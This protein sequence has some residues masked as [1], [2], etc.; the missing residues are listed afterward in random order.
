MNMS[1]KCNNTLQ[2]ENWIVDH[3]ITILDI[4]R[5]HAILDHPLQL[6]LPAV[7]FECLG[8][9]N[10]KEEKYLV[11]CF[12]AE[13]CEISTVSFPQVCISDFLVYL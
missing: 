6:L 12:K 5:S 9:V 2:Q 13:C 3:G 4:L 11:G 1:D 10:I 7:R 8:G